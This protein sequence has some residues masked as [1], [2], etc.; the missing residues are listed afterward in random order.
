[1]NQI[2]MAA[3]ETVGAGPRHGAASPA[4]S[5]EQI[6]HLRH[7]DNLSRQPVND[8]SLMGTRMPG[9]E[10][11]SS[12]RFQLAYMIYG[13]AIAH[14]N[15][16]PAAPGLFQPMI[17]R[18]MKKLMAPEVWMYW[19]DTSRGHAPF[20]EHLSHTYVEQWDPVA[21]D[22]IMYSAYVQSCALLHDYLFESDR[23][24]RPGSITF[25]HWTPLWGGPEKK[26]SYDRESLNDL[27]YWQMVKGGF[28]G[29]ACEPNCVFQICNQ[30]AILAFRLHDLLTG[31]S[32]AREVIASYES[33]WAE[34]GRLDANGH[35]N[36]LML[37]DTHQLVPNA[38]AWADA[39]CGTLMHMWN[40]GFVK[41]H[42]RRQVADFL[43]PQSDGTLSVRPTPKTYLGAPA[44]LD[45]CD[46]GWT[47][48]WAAEVG[49]WQTRDGILAYADRN[50][51]PTW[52]DGGLY[53]PR[54]DTERD[55]HGRYVEMDP[56][57]GNV[58]LGLARLMPRDG[59]FWSLFNRPLRPGRGQL[60]AVTAVDRNVEVSA[61]FFEDECLTV[62][63]RRCGDWPGDGG[64][65]VGN[66]LG[67]GNWDLTL[68][69]K[70]VAS[71]RDTSL[72]PC[73][74]AGSDR[75]QS[76]ENGISIRLPD[77]QPVHLQVRKVH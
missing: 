23:Y 10:D 1:M 66:V 26:F 35:Y 7:F 70:R 27:I 2:V 37:E 28:V 42:Y 68:D 39:W 50:M 59:G 38:G 33:A 44:D 11:F 25:Q 53:Y 65:V 22:N 63:L 54:N 64:I 52:R 30:P 73:S 8:W 46:F 34:Y 71:I 14:Q 31:G 21:R 55:E 62:G 32:R 67:R 13:A 4:L 75:V 57:V 24:A 61:A 5:K 3:P 56:M 45:W 20:N 12:L 18:L 76:V 16:L 43:V 41:E 58:L 9:Q 40:D 19:K 47:A 17:Q 77:G 69:G 6:G 15:W 60:P 29:I 36:T 48:A 74:D 51:Q 49:D 72:R